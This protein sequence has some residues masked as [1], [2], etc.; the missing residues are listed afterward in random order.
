MKAVILS[1]LMLG[2]SV[3]AAKDPGV[4]DTEVVL[5]A[6]TTE[7]GLFAINASQGRATTAYFEKVNKEG[8]I[9]GRKVKYIRVD[10][11][12][13]YAKALQAARKLV[14]QDKIFAFFLGQGASHQ[15][16]YKYLVQKGVPDLYI[17]DGLREYTTPVK[18]LVFAA[19][20]SSESEGTAFGEWVVKNMQGKKVC[21]LITD[22][23]LGEEILKSSKEA[24]EAG[25]K[26][27]PD[28]KKV[29]F[30]PVERADRTAAQA[31]TQ[32]LKLKESGCDAV[33]ASTIQS[34]CP[35]AISYGLKQGF[36]PR[37]LVVSQNYSDG[38]LKLIPPEV[39]DGIISAADLA[40][41][42]QFGVPGWNDYVK[43]MKENNIPVTK[44]SA[45]GYAFAESMAEVLKRAGKDLTRDSI[46]KT[47]EGM[48]GFKCSLCLQASQFSATNHQN[49]TPHLVVTKGGKWV[50]L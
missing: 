18:K 29:V 33:I 26:N 41:S 21:H 11:Q 6:H 27:L 16:T 46:V 31:D 36:K 5:G 14:E 15:A 49:F 22:Q 12:G 30:G 9:A 13:D 24:I 40:G 39:A 20:H 47:M 48:G 7:S 35:A 37:W 25:N 19:V 32:V 45:V 23:A 17:N 38:F 1:I 3:S 34:L 43:L 10:V 2:A 8:G 50:P 28:G 44:T 42:D 4:T